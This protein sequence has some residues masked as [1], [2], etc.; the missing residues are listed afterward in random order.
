MLSPVRSHSS[1]E[2]LQLSERN[3]IHSEILSEFFE[4]EVMRAYGKK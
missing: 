3:M 4:I 2:V 1:K